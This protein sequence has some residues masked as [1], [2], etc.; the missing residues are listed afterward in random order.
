MYWATSLVE[1]H[2]LKHPTAL[3]GPKLDHRMNTLLP[4]GHR[5]QSG[6]SSKRQLSE[7]LD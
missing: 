4:S 3:A 5:E 7:L 2:E 1:P 6:N